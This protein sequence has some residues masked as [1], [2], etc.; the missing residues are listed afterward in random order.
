[1][2]PAC[3]ACGFGAAAPL[4]AAPS[5]T[6]EPLPVPALPSAATPAAPAA[7]PMALASAGRRVGA[8]FI[9]LAIRLVVLGPFT[10]WMLQSYGTTVRTATSVQTRIDGWPAVA[11]FLGWFVVTLAYHSL[12][13]LAWGGS[14]GKRL[15]GMRVV[16]SD[17]GRIGLGQSVG[18]N[19]MRVV[20]AFFAYIVGFVAMLANPQRK[21]LGD[22]AAKTLVVRG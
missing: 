18:R 7:P 13:E 3:P 12:A 14:P 22:L 20:D 5:T 19:A 16:R 11:L 2:A 21:R 1:M 8:H 15:L 4:A 6:P 9:D 17:G 10:V